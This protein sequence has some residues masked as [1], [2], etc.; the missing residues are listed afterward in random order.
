MVRLLNERVWAG[1]TI[2]II[3]QGKLPARKLTGLRLHTRTVVRDGPHGSSA[4]RVCAARSL[5]SAAVYLPNPREKVW[6]VEARSW[7][8]VQTAVKQAVKE[9]V[10]A[11]EHIFK[12][13]TGSQEN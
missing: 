12:K 4:A 9:A 11:S 1:V 2:R 3:G 6:P 13:K 8:R 5:T 7:D 10:R